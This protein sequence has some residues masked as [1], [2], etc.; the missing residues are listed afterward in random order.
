MNTSEYLFVQYVLCTANE[1]DSEL[2]MT[3]TYGSAMDIVR[4]A[5]VTVTELDCDDDW[6]D[7]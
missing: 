3:L 2:V 1:G 7:E 6:D 5:G 4:Q